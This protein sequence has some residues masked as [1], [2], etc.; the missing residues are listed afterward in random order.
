[1]VV[2]SVGGGAC[3]GVFHFGSVDLGSS[4]YVTSDQTFATSKIQWKHDGTLTVTLGGSASTSSVTVPATATY[5]P[6]PALTDL[7]GNGIT[8]SASHGPVGGSSSHF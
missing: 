3:G 1:M 8:G 4:A 2:S 6:D 7:A 5:T